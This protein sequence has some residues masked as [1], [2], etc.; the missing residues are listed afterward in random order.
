MRERD[1]LVLEPH[2]AN[3]AA[4]NTRTGALVYTG[5]DLERE[6]EI[7]NST[8]RDEIHD[9]PATEDDL[10]SEKMKNLKLKKDGVLEL[11]VRHQV[12]TLQNLKKLKLK[13]I[14]KK[15]M[16]III[17]YVHIVRIFNSQ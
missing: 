7:F 8:R 14:H 12:G 5:D 13:L 9:M 15:L 3:E 16:C 4:K 10:F 11:L 6:A 17:F 2:I 1:R